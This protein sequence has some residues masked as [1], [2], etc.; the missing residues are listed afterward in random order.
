MILLQK[1]FF[2]FNILSDLITIVLITINL[3][4]N[5]KYFILFNNHTIYIILN[6]LYT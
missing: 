2:F 4:K 3:F 6:I 1:L 5:S